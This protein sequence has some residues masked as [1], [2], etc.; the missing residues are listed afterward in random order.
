MQLIVAEKPS[1]GITISRALGEKYT[2]NEG[3]MESANFI[4]TWCVGH[5]VS[6]ADA[7]AYDEKYTK[8][9]ISDLPIIPTKWKLAILPDKKKQF[10]VVK[11]LMNDK[12][13]DEIV[14][15]TEVG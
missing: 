3:Y 15:A 9:S 12:R 2:K 14:C 10:S 1:V 5:L 6:F 8:W 7:E 4:I 11:K 13:V